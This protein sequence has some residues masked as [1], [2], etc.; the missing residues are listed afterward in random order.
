MTLQ[1]M[2]VVDVLTVVVLS[3]GWE[4]CFPKGI[5]WYQPCYPYCWALR[6]VVNWGKGWN[7][8]NMAPPP[9][10]TLQWEETPSVPTPSLISLAPQPDAGVP[11]PS[12]PHPAAPGGRQWCRLPGSAVGCQ[13]SSFRG[14]NCHRLTGSGS[15]QLPHPVRRER[16]LIPN[17]H[18]PHPPAQ[19][20]V[21]SGHPRQT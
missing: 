1:A 12:T 19:G 3:C 2:S 11:L 21:G 14:H 6:A 18:S 10:D 15:G 20:L 8:S 17:P 13:G 9:A 4:Q 5:R 16:N 7:S